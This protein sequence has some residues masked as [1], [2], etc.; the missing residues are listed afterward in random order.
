MLRTKS[1]SAMSSTYPNS[2]DS[3]CLPMSRTHASCSG[4]V[5]VPQIAYVR[6]GRVYLRATASTEEVTLTRHEQLAAAAAS[7]DAHAA[8]DDR[9]DAV[10]LAHD[11]LCGAGDLVRDCDLGRVQL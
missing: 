2:S 8:H 1:A 5:A 7:L 9:R 10:G 3:N 6:T 11:E 4:E